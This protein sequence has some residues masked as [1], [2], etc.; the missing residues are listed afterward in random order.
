MQRLAQ[1]VGEHAAR[2]T[3][4]LVYARSQNNNHLLTEAAGLFTAGVFLPGHP[5]APG[6]R[7]L[8]WRWLHWG[9]QAQI[10]ADGAYI[11]NSANYHRLM[12]QAALWGC[13]V[14]GI[15]NISFPLATLERL[16][17]ATRWLIKLVDPPSGQ[18]PNLG[19]NDGAYILPLTVCP[20]S[21][22]RPLLQAAS[23]VFLGNRPYPQGP[24]D[25]ME[26]WLQTAAG[27]RPPNSDEK[28]RSAAGGPLV[29]HRTPHILRSLSG[30]S[31][32]Y[33]RVARYAA[34]P[35]HADQLHLDLWWRGL[36]VAQDA[37]TYLYNGSPPWENALS[38]TFVHNTI[39]IDG[40]EQMTRAGRFLWLDWAQGQIVSGEAAEDSTWR[41]LIALHNGYRRLGV[42]HEREVLARQD[43][44]WKVEDRLLQ[45]SRSKISRNHSARL[46]WLLPDWP[47]EMS[48]D[49]AAH[50]EI[51]LKSALGWIVLRIQPGSTEP[52]GSSTTVLDSPLSPQI[53]RAGELR[54]GSGPVEPTWGWMSPTYGL[55][56][57][58]LSF[59]IMA[60]GTLPFS[61]ASEW[62]FPDI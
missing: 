43:G 32:A 44:G 10:A 55:K 31:W 23:Q 25:E 42:I 8:G 17:E 54:Y 41:R 34:R 9:L 20:F 40:R 15:Q 47:W 14:A 4:T 60:Q 13:R 21:D 53:V 19:P 35:G 59:S 37:G 38:S 2:I 11:Q 12:L 22:Y 16:S 33:L 46:H 61:L 27:N 58:A 18:A 49:G 29:H 36:N 39:A 30:D 45:V 48:E 1:A 6:W 24:W 5:S 26:L 62:S 56:I 57:P 7:K 52:L 51:R 28:Q 3:P 50:I